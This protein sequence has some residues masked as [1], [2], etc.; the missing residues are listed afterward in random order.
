MLFA[1]G[2]MED[3]EDIQRSETNKEIYRVLS[4]V[5]WNLALV[6]LLKYV[7]IVLKADDNGEGG[8]FSLY[9]LLCQRQCWVGT[10]IEFWPE[11]EIYFREARGFAKV[12]T[13]IRTC[14]VIGD[15]ILTPAISGK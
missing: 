3:N 11:V 12:L 15:G 7:F 5:L 10:E 4:F 14:M 2:I 9:S 6:P 13:L 1:E 8:T